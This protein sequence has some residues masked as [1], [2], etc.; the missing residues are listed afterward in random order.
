M[1]RGWML[2]SLTTVCADA[3]SEVVV[4]DRRAVV[5]ADDLAD[6]RIELIFPPIPIAEGLERHLNGD[7]VPLRE[8]GAQPGAA[9]IE[10]HLNI[11][12]RDV[13]MPGRDRLSKAY[14]D[15]CE[16]SERRLGDFGQLETLLEH[17]GI[18]RGQKRFV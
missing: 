12:D 14:S 2:Y 1:N 5:H 13:P 10:P 15:F 3:E 4:R 6:T 11:L 9:E 7:V 18:K 16:R 17:F 8:S